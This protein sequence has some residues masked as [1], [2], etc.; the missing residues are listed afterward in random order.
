MDLLPF[1]ADA[2]E[3]SDYELGG[4]LLAWWVMAESHNAGLPTDNIP[5]EFAERVRQRVL[6]LET[7]TAKDAPVEKALH[8]AAGGDF[9]AAGKILRE[10][11]K[12]G[13]DQIIAEKYVPIGMTKVVRDKLY[14]RLGAD[15]KRQEGEENRRSVEDAA[16]RIL[17]KYQKGGRTPPKQSTLKNLVAKETGLSP[18][19]VG[20]HLK[21]ISLR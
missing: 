21:I 8:K 13:A 18:K 20:R 4:L 17:E 7:Q 1:P 10:H 3:H 12:R 15:H 16:R 6:T 11:L 9:N 5:E 2:L 14:G 19:T